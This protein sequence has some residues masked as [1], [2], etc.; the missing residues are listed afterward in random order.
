MGNV[1]AEGRFPTVAGASATGRGQHRRRLDHTLFEAAAATPGVT[2]C[3]GM[4]VE[5]PLWEDGRVAGLVVAG[6]ARRA[7]LVVAAD[8]ARSRLRRQLGLER[9]P[10]RRWRIGMR[11]HFRLAPGRGQ[12]PWVEVFLGRGYELYVT[13]LP[14]G[15]ILVAG[16]AERSCIEG[17]A[18]TAYEHWIAEQPVL[19]M[20]LVGAERCST[21]RGMSPLGTQARSGVAPGIVLLG[22]AAG[23]LDPITGTGMAQALLSA[24]LLAQYVTRRWGSGDTWLYAYDRARRALLRDEW[25]LTQLVLGIAAHPWLARQT[26]RLLNC[27]PPLF[28]HLIGIV[29]GVGGM[30]GCPGSSLDHSSSTSSTAE[31]FSTKNTRRSWRK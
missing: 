24:E 18:E 25:L 10:P 5:A 13:P 22:D 12:P 20:R 14:D 17:K 30:H 15:E 9:P 1:Q 2:A 8:G 7:P 21:L 23:A 27:V 11:R 6:K 3:A 26:L 31:I 16:L 28:S 4:P 19:R 29:G